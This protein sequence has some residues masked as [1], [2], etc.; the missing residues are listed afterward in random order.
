MSLM[1]SGLFCNNLAHFW[2]NF[3]EHKKVNKMVLKGPKRAKKGK[4]GLRKA[5]KYH[6]IVEIGPKFVQ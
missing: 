1:H 5:Q 2:G 6:E 4:K 3:R